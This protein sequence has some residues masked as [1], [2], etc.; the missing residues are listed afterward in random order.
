MLPLIN[1]T[2]ATQLP[3][4][5][6]TTVDVDPTYLSAWKSLAQSDGFTERAR[7]YDTSH[8]DELGTDAPA[9]PPVRR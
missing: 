3:G 5:R 1:G 6:L 9:G 8:C 2:A 7:V 4:A